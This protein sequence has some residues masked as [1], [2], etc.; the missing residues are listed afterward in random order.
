MPSNDARPDSRRATGVHSDAG[1]I[2][3]QASSAIEMA[4][5]QKERSHELMAY[6]RKLVA[7]V[8][9]SLARTRRVRNLGQGANSLIAGEGGGQQHG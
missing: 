9:L 7:R 4:R 6:S 3:Q 8:K 2:L 5:R 1:A